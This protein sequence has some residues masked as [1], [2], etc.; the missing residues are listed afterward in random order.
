MISKKIKEILLGS[1]QSER[2][3]ALETIEKIESKDI[4]FLVQ[5]AWG[6]DLGY[7]DKVVR[8]IATVKDE[9]S[10]STI[11]TILFT[12]TEVSQEPIRRT[13]LDVL[14]ANPT[15]IATETLFNTARNQKFYQTQCQAVKNLGTRQSG[16][17]IL[18][19]LH[20]IIRDGKHIPTTEEMK[21]E[22]YRLISCA[23]EALSSETLRNEESAKVILDKISDPG[24]E[25]IYRQKGV[26]Y[27]GQMGFQSIVDHTLDMIKQYPNNTNVVFPLL[28]LLTNLKPTKEQKHRVHEAIGTML[29]IA[30]PLATINAD[31][32]DVMKATLDE[33]LIDIITAKTFTWELNGPA[34]SPIVEML[35]T[36]PKE[37]PK[38]I[39][40]LL[41]Y[42]ETPQ[43]SVNKMYV[44]PNLN[45]SYL[46]NPLEVIR[47]I[48]ESNNSNHKECRDYLRQQQNTADNREGLVK[49][50]CDSIEIFVLNRLEDIEQF[51]RYFSQY[52]GELQNI[53]PPLLKD[54]IDEINWHLTTKNC[55]YRLIS[56]STKLNADE[57]S[58]LEEELSKLIDN[59]LSNSKTGPEFVERTIDDCFLRQNRTAAKY[60]LTIACTREKHRKNTIHSLV[61]RAADFFQK[62]KT[63]TL[64]EKSFQ[65]WVSQEIVQQ[66]KEDCKPMLVECLI[67]DGKFNE[68]VYDTIHQHSLIDVKIIVRGLSSDISESYT[69]RLLEDLVGTYDKQAEEVLVQKID[70]GQT[71]KIRTA[72]IKSAGTIF[73][74]NTGR[75]CPNSILKAINER[76][77]EQDKEVREAA[78]ISLGKICSEQSI[79]SLLEAKIKDKKLGAIITKSL[80]NIFTKF[81]KTKPDQNNIETTI[82][83]IKVIGKLGDKRGFELLTSYVAPS[84]YHRDESVRIAAVQAM[85]KVGSSENILFFE[86]LK[87]TESHVPKIVEEIDRSIGLISN[88]GDFELSEIFR[89]LTD[90]HPTFSNSQLDLAKILGDKTPT[91]KYQC[92]EAHKSW[93]KGKYSLYATHLDNVCDLVAKRI[94][95]VFKDDL[96]R[97]DGAKYVGVRRNKNANSRY[98]FLKANFNLLL[99]SCFSTVHALR[100]ENPIPHAEDTATD[101]P[102]EE[103]S[104]EDGELAKSNFTTAITK[105][106][107]ML[108]SKLFAEK[109]VPPG[110]NT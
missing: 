87:A 72:A 80:D 35:R 13:C 19:F 92:L 65:K 98:E 106:V 7:L 101:Q 60:V 15:Q 10:A 14:S 9:K 25:E 53:V 27:L 75:Q 49:N 36:C 28:R 42:A 99:G 4:D 85:G 69:I 20:E 24:C 40:A 22:P 41:R 66:W 83:W 82:A 107:E 63:C 30:N 84:S 89:K 43:W 55:L 5:T 71:T 56:L 62:Q 3:I 90:N 78:Y 29:T 67:K 37:S 108:K 1:E 81:S 50:I 26:E 70:R 102:K 59:F 44:L 61:R 96:F 47:K 93:L 109:G 12:C 100:V 104:H 39:T 2:M 88:V 48:Y 86:N 33:D 79:D 18:E 8:I 73:D 11:D 105:A 94:L 74:C 16:E 38:T 6:F 76:F 57:R 45:A 91:I 17:K 68:W 31:L 32:V 110:N 23:L 52:F 103:L 46:E 51:K 95:D 54:S 64:D 34:G 97:G 21:R 77:T 58:I